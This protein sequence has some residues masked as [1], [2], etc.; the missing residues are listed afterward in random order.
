MVYPTIVFAHGAWHNAGFFHKVIGI[1]EPLGYRCVTVSLPSAS[2]RVPPTSSLDE[3]IA[4]IRDVVLR[5][6]DSGHDVLVN[7]HSWGAIPTTTGLVGLSKPERQATGKTTGIVK[8]AFVAAFVLPE[9]TSL[10]D[11][12]GGPQPTWIIDSDGNVM[13]GGDPR[14]LFY[15]DVEQ[16]E[17]DEWIAKLRPHSLASFQTKTTSAAWK[18]IPSA[19]LIC[20]DDQL[21]PPQAQEMM[22]ANMKEEGGAVETTHIAGSHS[23]YLANPEAVVKFLR[24]AAGESL[25]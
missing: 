23:P 15:H 24:A 1:L 6:L 18:K 22:V 11:A 7:A 10:Q 8:L 2:G 21:L 5:E 3:D 9:N 12:L 19:Y 20:D 13:D 16:K 25:S 17:A 4:A 14:K